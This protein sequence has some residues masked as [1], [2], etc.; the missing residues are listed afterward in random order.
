MKFN[1]EKLVSL[2]ELNTIKND[3]YVK[4]SVT[5]SP[6]LTK[7]K[8]Y[9]LFDRNMIEDDEGFSYYSDKKIFYKQVRDKKDLSDT[10]KIGKKIDPSFYPPINSTTTFDAIMGLAGMDP[11]SLH[12]SPTAPTEPDAMEM[13]NTN[14]L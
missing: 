11:F 10:K 2:K 3:S 4:S 5:I 6:Y 9:R 7:D 13:P 14:Q 1:E 12:G 8:V